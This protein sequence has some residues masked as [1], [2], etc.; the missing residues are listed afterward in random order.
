[1]RRIDHPPLAQLGLAL[2]SVAFVRLTL[3]FDLLHYH[4]R[5]GTPILN[6]FLYTYLIAAAAFAFAAWKLPAEHSRLGAVPVTPVL[7]GCVG[8]LLFTLLNI[9]IAD[10]FTAEG[11]TYVAIEFGG[12]F[13][14]SMTYSIAWGLFALGL[15]ILGLWKR[16][17]GARYA[18]IGLLAITLL[19]L[20]FHDL[21][22]IG[23]L[24]RIAAFF[25]VAVIALTAS[26]LYQRFSQGESK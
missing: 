11:S 19:K 17:A 9:E 5:S 26:W 4:T 24:Y 13:A 15:I 16:Q 6:W 25:V 8:I 7:W 22:S 2:L 23:Q 20:F 3:N 1:M 21:S 18:G 14:R 10:A 12:N